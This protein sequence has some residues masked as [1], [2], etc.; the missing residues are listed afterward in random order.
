MLWRRGA[1]V[2]TLVCFSKGSA[3]LS[4]ETL[5]IERVP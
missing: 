4:A 2:L 3:A 5:L 1:E